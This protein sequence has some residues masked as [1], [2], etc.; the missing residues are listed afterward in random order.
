ME[1]L[2]F[3]FSVKAS[4][5]DAKTNIFILIDFGKDR[6]NIVVTPIE[7]GNHEVFIFPE[8][9]QPIEHH[10]QLK[11]TEAFKKVKTTLTRRGMT[12]KM[13]ISADK[14]LL[15]KYKDKDGNIQFNDYLLEEKEL[16]PVSTKDDSQTIGISAEAL[17][18]ILNKFSEMHKPP[19][20]NLKK[21][22]EKFVINTFTGKCVSVDGKL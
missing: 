5:T 11:E 20:I 4:A 1:K 22:S 2:R 16:E 15:N 19:V 17:E 7:T 3:Q 8:Q 14:E 10:V 9:Y 6:S 18:K 21:V 13:W 12:R